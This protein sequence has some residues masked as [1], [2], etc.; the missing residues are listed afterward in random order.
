MKKIKHSAICSHCGR[1]MTR[2]SLREAIAKIARG[3]YFWYSCSG[4]KK[5]KGCGHAFVV[6]NMS[7][8]KRQTLRRRS[9]HEV[10]N[11]SL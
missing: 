7:K 10:K 2:L 11:I 4:R 3:T 8:H 5:E 1:E 6:K 9:V